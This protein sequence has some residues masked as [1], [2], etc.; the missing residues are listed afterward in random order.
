MVLAAEI[1]VLVVML[2]KGME[3]LALVVMVVKV[4][5]E[6]MVLVAEVVLVVAEVV[7]VV[8]EVMFLV[9][10]T[11]KSATIKLTFFPLSICSC[12]FI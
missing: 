8:A 12:Y 10:I 2:E 1:V 4:V 11:G 7:A 9:L 6:V 5:K 3:V